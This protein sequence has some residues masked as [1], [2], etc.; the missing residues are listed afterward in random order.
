MESVLR[1]SLFTRAAY[2]FLPP[3]WVR[4]QT[5]R[6]R[7]QPR[8]WTDMDDI[9]ATE[10]MQR[11]GIHAKDAESAKQRKWFASAIP[12]TLSANTSMRLHQHGMAKTESS[13]SCRNYSVPSR[14]NMCKRCSA[15]S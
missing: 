3:P 2:L 13:G 5:E 4:D 6:T 12:S 14:L 9:R 11:E 1:F 15:A 7:C 10:W 8:L